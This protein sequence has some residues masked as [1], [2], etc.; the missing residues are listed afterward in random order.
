MLNFPFW[1]KCSYCFPQI[2]CNFPAGTYKHCFSKNRC[3][4]FYSLFI[5]SNKIFCNFINYIWITENSFKIC[6]RLFTLLYLIFICSLSFAFCIIR[7]NLLN[8]LVVQEN[9]CG[10]TFINEIYSD[11]IC[12]RFFHG[13]SINNITKNLLHFIYWSSSKTNISGVRK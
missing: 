9:F 11:S 13:V 2:K 7:F 4:F 8:F 1:T 10:T 5:M 12:N 6:N 3:T